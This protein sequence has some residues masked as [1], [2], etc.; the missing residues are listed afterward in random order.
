M[1]VNGFDN[2]EKIAKIV[3]IEEF[4]WSALKGLFN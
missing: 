4:S 1:I 2:L 3:K